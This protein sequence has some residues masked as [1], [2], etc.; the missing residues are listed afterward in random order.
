MGR[1]KVEIN[2]IRGDRLNKL[3]AKNGMSQKDLAETIG[4]TKEHISYI[5]NGRRNLTDD[6]AQ[7]IV[8]LFPPTR[9]EWLMGYDDFET[10]LLKDGYIALKPFMEKKIREKAV[11]AFF[12]A[13]NLTF[14]PNV[15][16]NSTLNLNI[17]DF[18]KLPISEIDSAMDEFASL[19]KTDKAYII[20]KD[21]EVLGYC[22]ND[23]RKALFEEI[24]S[25]V[26]FKLSRLCDRRGENNG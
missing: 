7:A 18:C 24:F 21:N 5:V 2:T 6:A 12:K 8:K 26:E 10:P 17:T 1:K 23:E 22:S 9:F 3:L 16:D 15:P 14:K 19:E 20:K 25:F 13:V 4:Y 11:T